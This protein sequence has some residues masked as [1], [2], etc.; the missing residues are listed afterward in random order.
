MPDAFL[1]AEE[2]DIAARLASY[3]R[4]ITSLRTANLPAPEA[5]SDWIF[6]HARKAFLP[7]CAAT[8]AL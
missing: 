2:E 4:K 8:Q 6:P 1:S 7:L 5:F 3:H